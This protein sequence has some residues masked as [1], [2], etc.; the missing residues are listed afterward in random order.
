M[1]IDA[2][3]EGRRVKALLLVAI[4]MIAGCTAPGPVPDRD[5]VFVEMELVDALGTPDIIGEARC[6]AGVCQIKLRRDTY[7]ACITHE[8]RHAFEGDFHP[9]RASTEDCHVPN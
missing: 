9:G 2:D 7:P 5:K 4:L 3:T 6:R 1:G 8:I